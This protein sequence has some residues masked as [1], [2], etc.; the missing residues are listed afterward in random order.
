MGGGRVKKRSHAQY[1]RDDR[2]NDIGMGTT[3]A[4][5]RNSD[6]AESTMHDEEPDSIDWEVVSRSK[7]KQKK[8]NYPSL[9]YSD[10]HRLQS[11]VKLGDLQGLVLYCLADGTSPQWVSLTHH[12]MVKKA[13]VL[14]VPGLELDMFKGGLPMG[15]TLE[16]QAKREDQAPKADGDP[17]VVY[18]RGN[19]DSPNSLAN[20]ISLNSQH[21]QDSAFST[22][23]GPSPDDYMPT[24]LESMQ[25]PEVFKPLENM[26]EHVWPIKAP[27]D[28]RFGRVHSPLQGMLQCPIS[29][30]Q[31]QRN[32][33]K[34]VK[35]PKLATG[36]KH[37]ESKRTPVP[38]Y[39]LSTEVLQENEYVLHP[40]NIPKGE[41]ENEMQR[42]ARDNQSTE[43]GWTD[44]QVCEFEDATVP[45]HDI[46]Q[47]SLLQGRK[48]LAMDCEMCQVEGDEQALTRVS[49]VEWDGTTIMD[50]L[51]KPDLPITDYLTPYSGM[52][53]EKLDP[54]T[55]NLAQ[56]QERMIALLTPQTI[57]VGHSL[58]A[59]LS[60]LK[61]T[62]PF[63]IDTALLYPHPRGPPLKSSLKWL[64]QKYLGREIQKGHG[65]TGHDS[66]EDA[67]ACLD[68]VKLKCEKGPN[69]GTNE[70]TNEPIFKRLKRSSA[71]GSNRGGGEGNGR[72]GAIIDHGHPERN[73]GQ[74]ASYCV[75]CNTDSE[76]V[77]AVK[78]A[79]LGDDDGRYFPGG[80]VDF[81][82]ARLRELEVLRGWRND[83]PVAT[84]PQ[85][86][87]EPEA[88]ASAVAQ[89][90]LNVQQVWDC[91]PPCTLLIV[92]SGTGDP[93]DMAR[94]QAIQ[95]RY[96]KEF[97][98][99]KW[100]ELSVKWTDV[101]EQAL[102]A[103]V[104]KARSGLGLVA[105]KQDEDV[106][107]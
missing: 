56:V 68:L 65:S 5:L 70:A 9:A 71:P 38:T 16:A 2:P 60:A 51:V 92:Y 10:L 104:K 78:R 44:A 11:S 57:L 21:G 99:K 105:I 3:V 45:L 106:L 103:A 8:R 97:Q 74:M 80:G 6:L 24:K 30:T 35:G 46:E 43:H 39:I 34:D 69:W 26:F 40:A 81:T 32:L 86:N 61:L 90:V 29:K 67:V 12:N 107:Y 4:H 52:T 22:R 83:D 1:T 25:L 91:L 87:P 49:L 100:D 102:K 89:T 54:V 93:R 27:G 84:S 59:D 37:F 58:N 73:F 64:A 72:Q 101:E 14:F 28:D 55:T 63:I 42:R 82:W 47:G 19:T 53:A 41:R 76:I 66:I 18:I 75:G 88:L 85:P 62:H 15:K 17:S 33:E 98:T 77:A 7:K 31:E 23:N 48:V 96:K 50:E 20:G 95:R 13:V 94:L 36:G 79:V